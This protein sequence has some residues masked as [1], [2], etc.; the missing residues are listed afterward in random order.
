MLRGEEAGA[1]EGVGDPDGCPAGVPQS[2]DVVIGY[3]WH[4]PRDDV[5]SRSYGAGGG[6]A[7]LVE[8]AA[9]FLEW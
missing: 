9:D 6:D 5:F 1:G 2:G 3:R 8:F 4:S 7:G